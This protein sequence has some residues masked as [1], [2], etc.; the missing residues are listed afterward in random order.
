MLADI[1]QNIAS[2]KDTDRGMWFSMWILLSFV[3]FGAAWFLMIYYLIKRRNEHFARQKKLENLVLTKFRQLHSEKKSTPPDS[4][5]V[6]EGND[7]SLAFRNASG[8]AASTI[9]ILPTFYVLRFLMEDLRK[10]EEYE[11][12]FFREVVSYAKNLELSMNLNNMT[13]REK[14]LPLERFL[15]L[16]LGTLGFAG[17][18]W[19]YLIFNDYNKHF[20]RQWTVEDELLKALKSTGISEP[21]LGA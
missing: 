19:L 9:L 10:H 13:L 17:F 21:A 20:K 7:D 8:W 1:E 16:T 11:S 5:T 18:Y 6:E 4:T 15:V 12:I 3:T 14:F 2:R